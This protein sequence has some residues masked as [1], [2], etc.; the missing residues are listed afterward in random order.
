MDSGGKFG[1]DAA[2]QA[3]KSAEADAMFKLVGSGVR[4]PTPIMFYEGC[5]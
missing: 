2:E 5:C 3:W 4:S 1:R